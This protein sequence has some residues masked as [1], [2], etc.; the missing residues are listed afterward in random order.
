MRKKEPLLTAAHRPEPSA[1][2]PDTPL[3]QLKVR[4]LATL[5]GAALR[6]KPLAAEAAPKSH[7]KDFFKIEKV[8]GSKFEIGVKA[9][10]GKFEH[11]EPKGGLEPGPDPQLG[12]GIAEL[13]EVVTELKS[14]VDQL[15][16]QIARGG[17]P[18]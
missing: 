6:A 13:I 14:A 5:L 9:E 7:L 18:K 16:R 11:G 15:G 10:L 2:D 17:K 3:S 12:R 4:D 8:E 1:P